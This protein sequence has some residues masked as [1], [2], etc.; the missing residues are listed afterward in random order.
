MK[1]KETKIVTASVDYGCQVF[2]D[3]EVSV[4]A[5]KEDLEM[6][7]KEMFADFIRD[8]WSFFEP[9]IQILSSE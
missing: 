4:D 5:S 8:E 1:E 3:A 6:I 9:E 7:F 2:L